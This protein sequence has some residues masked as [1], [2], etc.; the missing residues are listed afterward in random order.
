MWLVTA[1]V[2]P[3]CWALSMKVSSLIELQILNHYDA[4]CGHKAE[5]DD[6]DGGQNELIA[7]VD[8]RWGWGGA[9][10]SICD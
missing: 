4:Y 2:A 7:A 3:T 8:L 10:D 6:R 1:A 5:I 9:G